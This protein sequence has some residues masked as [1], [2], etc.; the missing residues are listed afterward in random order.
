MEK[1]LESSLIVSSKQ[2]AKVI[3]VYAYSKPRKLLCGIDHRADYLHMLFVY[4]DA[5]SD[6]VTD[7]ESMSIKLASRSQ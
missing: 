7:K 3:S 6:T 1:E 5:H 2:L 4:V